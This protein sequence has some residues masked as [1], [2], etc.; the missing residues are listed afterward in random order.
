[1]AEFLEKI[2]ATTREDVEARKRKLPLAAL[3]EAAA[4]MPA[5]RSLVEAIGSPG[6]SVIAEIKRASP[7]KGDIR[8]DLDVAAIASAYE[9]AGAAAISV[10]TEERHFKGSLED[11]RLARAACG[12]PIL[13]KDFIIDSYQILEAAAAGARRGAADR[14]GSGKRSTREVW[15]RGP[16][17]RPRLPGGSP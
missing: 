12:L 1:M 16:S 2:L 11:L 15:G 13:R 4:A 7:S 8:P 9:Q 5:G 6:M 10:L 14:G 3:A 17:R